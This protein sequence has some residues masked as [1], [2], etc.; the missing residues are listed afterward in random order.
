MIDHLR[1]NS[2]LH[3]G[4]NEPYDGKQLAYSIDLQGTAAGLPNAAIESRQDLISDNQGIEFWA[5]LLGDALEDTLSREGLHH[6]E[7]F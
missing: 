4:D 5:R 3:I 2:D 7:H 1:A 6:V